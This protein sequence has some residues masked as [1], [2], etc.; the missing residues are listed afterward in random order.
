[1]EFSS[2]LDG[3]ATVLSP[4]TL[5]YIVLGCLLGTLIGLLPGIGPV[6]GTAILIPITMVLD[7]IGAIA[8]LAA[9]FY[10]SSYGSTITSVLINTPGEAA[11]AVTCI[12]GYPMT[13]K[14]KPGVALGIAAISSFIG[15]TIG[16]L[17]LAFA[18][19]P[20]GA[21]GLRIGPPEFFALMVFGMSMLIGLA[22]KS[23]VRALISGAAGLLLAMIGI[24]PV[25]G[26]PRFAFGEVHFYDGI[27]FVAVL[28]GLFGLSEVLSNILKPHTAGASTTIGRLLPNKEERRDSLPAIG[29]GGLVGFFMGVIPGVTGS[30]SSFLAYGAERRFAR[31]RKKFGTGAI[32]GVAGPESA[33]NAHNNASLIP[34][35]TLGVPGSPTIAVLMGAF[36]MNGLTPGPQMLSTDADIAWAII[37]SLFVG[38]VICLVLNLP[39]IRVWTLFLKIPRP[40]LMVLIIVFLVIG[41][42]SINNSMI[43]V[44]VMIAF[45]VLGLVFRRLDVPLA[46]MVLTLILG[47]F[48]ERA[49][50][51]SMNMSLGDFSI[52]VTRPISLILLILAALIFFVP[53]VNAVRAA[54]LRRRASGQAQTDHDESHSHT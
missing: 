18:A 21:L 6:A 12:D 51:Q 11:S 37:A 22:G 47:P 1:M 9:I 32:E 28:V 24:D 54:L 23:M 17:G 39:L 8:M 41:S 3:F 43:D 33:T 19:A 2:L 5:L 50:R 44:Y 52:F 42:Y 14:G 25:D 27:E 49:L 45:G 31:N 29:R 34:L 38:N 40:V 7:P 10:G 26:H 46:P 36:L 20:L 35:F 30:A 53:L 13:K 48:M 16:A 15:G 4:E